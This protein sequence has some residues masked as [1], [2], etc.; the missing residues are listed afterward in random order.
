[1]KVF[2]ACV[3]FLLGII[4]CGAQSLNNLNDIHADEEFDNIL[5]KTISSDSLSSSFL[6]WIKKSVK[7]HKH[8]AH[9]EQVYILEGTGLMQLGDS[10]FQISSGSFINIPKNTKHGVKV[11]S[12]N[13]MKV[14]S[15][16]SPKFEGEDRHFIE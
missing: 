6:I 4:H 5:V 7:L 2:V 15:I 16:Q 1:M 14:L 9:T 12:N 11:T 8:L 13:P 3:I 10:T